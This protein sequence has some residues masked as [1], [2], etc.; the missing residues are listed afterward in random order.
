MELLKALILIALMTLPALLVTFILLGKRA[1]GAVIIIFGVLSVAVSFLKLY[2]FV[3]NLILGKGYQTRVEEYRVKYIL[4]LG[5]PL[6]TKPT[7]QISIKFSVGNKTFKQISYAFRGLGENATLEVLYSP[8]CNEP[9]VKRGLI[10]QL[11]ER[12]FFLFM[13]LILLP[14]GFAI[15]RSSK[16]E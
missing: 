13:G 15:F 8:T 6:G 12:L 4:P 3:C 16:G 5:T 11:L 1:L 10:I 14:V 7:E 9:L 2:P